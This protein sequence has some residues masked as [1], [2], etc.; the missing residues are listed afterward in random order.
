MEVTEAETHIGNGHTPNRAQRRGFRRE[1]KELRLHFD[2]GDLDGF[3]VHMGPVSVGEI[4]DFAELG[5]KEERTAEE[6]MRIFTV[7][8]DHIEDWNHEHEQ[9]T[10]HGLP[11]RCPACRKANVVAAVEWVPTPVGM[12]GVRILGI[13]DA[14]MIM[15]TWMEQAA[16]V[17]DPLSPGSSNGPTSPVVSLPMEASSPSPL[18]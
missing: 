10:V 18:N 15:R 2:G 7:L 3:I 6:N 5:E 16:G 14:M 8:A 9:C 11:V 13:D 4:M 1:R 12:D 17:P